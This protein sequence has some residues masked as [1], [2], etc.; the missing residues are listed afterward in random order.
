M[1]GPTYLRNAGAVRA[2]TLKH[3]TRP[4]GKYPHAKV[5]GGGEI[6]LPGASGA[7]KNRRKHPPV[8]CAHRAAWER[9]RRRARVTP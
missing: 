6:V 3:V 5:A 1:S 2:G 8:G 9:Q 4:P 7:G